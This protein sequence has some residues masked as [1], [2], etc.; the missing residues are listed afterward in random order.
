M[1]SLNKSQIH[2]ITMYLI[3]IGIFVISIFV[4]SG[5]K[6]GL[7]KCYSTTFKSYQEARWDAIQSNIESGIEL[8][9]FGLINSSN[10]IQQE[11]KSK[12]DMD[13]LKHSLAN[14][15]S[16]PEFDLILR[17]A[18]EKN[19]FTRDSSGMDQSRNSIFVITNGKVIANYSHNKDFLTAN[20][21][22]GKTVYDIIN[23]TS[24]NPELCIDA[25]QKIE[26]QYNDVIIWQR[27]EPQNESIPKYKEMS[28][29]QLKEIFIEHGIDGLDSYEILIPVYIT[30]Y[31]NIFGE[32]DTPDTIENN[33]KLILIQRLNIKDYLSKYSP[34]ALID[35]D[36][37]S[38]DENYNS[39]MTYTHIFEC[40]LYIS[41][42][43]YITIVIGNLNRIIA[44]LDD[45][46]EEDTMKD[47]LKK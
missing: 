9:E 28:M 12:L 31:G 21:D 16:Y 11:V 25:L 38:L 1:K 13:Q 6:V 32:H 17:E 3:S 42:F 8:G 22:K 20:I 34:Y 19:V 4:V 44:E 24:F 47:S 43:C 26:N 14:N 33:N 45:D 5:F 30:S 18:L 7:K 46:E 10:K 29:T 40:I 23:E 36:I 27:N 15:E 37:E 41:I 39:L 35:L 2:R